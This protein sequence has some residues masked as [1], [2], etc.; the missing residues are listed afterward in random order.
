MKTSRKSSAFTLLELLVV[1]AVTAVLACTLLPALAKSSPNPYDFQCL[2]NLRQLMNGWKMYSDDYQ[3]R[4]VPNRSSSFPPTG[5]WVN[6]FM[7][8]SSSPMNTNTDNL[9]GSGALLGP[10]VRSASLFKCPGDKSTVVIAG[11][12]MARVRSISMN[13]WVGEGATSWNGSN[14]R[15]YQKT[16]DIVT[17]TPANLWVLIDEHES[18]INDGSFATAP[19]G[20][21]A[22]TSIVDYPAA[23]H[24]RGCGI[25]FAD[26]RAE[27]HRWRDPRTMPPPY[28]LLQFNI[29][30]PNNPDI[31]WLNQHST[32]PP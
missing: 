16:G 25:S 24:N 7:D 11:T 29:P 23:R 26:G 9:V 22:S 2:N 21:P 17:P 28:A 27:I 10:Y 15:L 31:Y 6:G 1:L 18:S 20:S 19:T 13:G 8:F 5:N 30:T 3:G 4:L 32:S 12:R 14:Y